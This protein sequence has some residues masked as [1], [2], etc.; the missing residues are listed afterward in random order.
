MPHVPNPTGKGGF[1]PGQSGNPGGRPKAVREVMELARAASPD[2]IQTLRDICANPDA[3]PAARV[4]AATALL[5]RGWGRPHQSTDT[6]LT[7]MR[8]SADELTDDEL[9]AIAAGGSSSPA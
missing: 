4:S 7:I 6:N 1:K 8:Q 5:D 3:P 2:A 9:A